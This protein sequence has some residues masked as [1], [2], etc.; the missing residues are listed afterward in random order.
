MP[1]ATPVP[2]PTSS[3]TPVPTPTPTINIPSVPSNVRYEVENSAIRVIWESVN[4]A[5][6]YNLYHHDFFDDR[7]S[8]SSDGVPRFCDELATNV[9]ED[10]LPPF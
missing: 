7:C 5:D 10:K 6:Y 1:T 2:T 9:S 8:L 4:D 3:P